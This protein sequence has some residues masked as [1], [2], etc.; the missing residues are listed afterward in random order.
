ML[1]NLLIIFF[2]FLILYQFL[3]PSLREGLETAPGPYM[4]YPN[5]PMILGKQNAGNIEVLRAEVQKVTTLEPRVVQLETDVKNLNEQLAGIQQQNSEAVS[6]F[7]NSVGGLTGATEE[8][9]D[10]EVVPGEGKTEGEGESSGDWG[11]SFG[12]GGEKEGETNAEGEGGE[13]SS[14]SWG[15]FGGTTEEEKES[16]S[17]LQ[18]YF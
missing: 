5:D 18:H 9:E 11:S 14:S 10:G 12:M 6:S 15:G 13:S 1:L 17:L 4:E 7:G 16:F 8:G 3:A 2:L